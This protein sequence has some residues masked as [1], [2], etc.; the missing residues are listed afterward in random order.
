MECLRFEPGAT[1]WKPQLN[2]LSYGGTHTNMVLKS[3]I[4]FGANIINLTS[5]P[6]SNF[7]QY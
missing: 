5:N 3:E 2:P 4:S 7:L 6:A 1:G